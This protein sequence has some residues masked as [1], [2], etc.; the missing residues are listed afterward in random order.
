MFLKEY[1][2]ELKLAEQQYGQEEELYPLVNRLLRDGDNIAD[3]SLRTVAGARSRK[4]T[5]E[6]TKTYSGRNFLKQYSSFPDMV[7]LDEKFDQTGGKE[8]IEY[9]YGCV[10]CKKILDSMKE[11]KNMILEC[12]DIVYIREK[13]KRQAYCWAPC[14]IN[15]NKIK[16][17][18]EG[19]KVA[20]IYEI[21]SDFNGISKITDIREKD[22]NGRKN[23]LIWY[24][25]SKSEEKH[26]E[27]IGTNK[28]LTMGNKDIEI[29]IDLN[30]IVVKFEGEE[31]KI[32][33]GDDLMQLVGEV[34]WYGKVL[35]TN[36]RVGWEVI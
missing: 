25:F 5:D 22:E 17:E 4:S 29:R 33:T 30:Q 2:R 9:I 26:G 31:A 14:T 32:A 34:L 24:K 19:K 1:L 27:K 15:R 3:L 13:G 8:Q 20:N 10:E 11:L 6:E 7:I 36:W 18:K 23:P 35:Y 12:R 21:F 16:G 28:K